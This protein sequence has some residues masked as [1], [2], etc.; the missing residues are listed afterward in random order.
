MRHDL[1][2]L[3]VTTTA[4]GGVIGIRVPVVVTTT[5]GA[6]EGPGWPN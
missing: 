2:T 3:T 5:T 6:Y 1:L 4:L